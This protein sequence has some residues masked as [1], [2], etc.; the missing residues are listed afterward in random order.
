[1]KTRKI[2]TAIEDT[3]S[4]AGHEA[5]PPLRKVAVVAVIENPYAGK[6][7]QGDLSS[8]TEASE[9][10]GRKITSMAADAMFLK[11]GGDVPGE[12]DVFGID[13][14]VGRREQMGLMIRDAGRMG[15]AVQGE[16][17]EQEAHGRNRRKPLALPDGFPDLGRRTD[18]AH[19]RR[20]AVRAHPLRDHIGRIRSTGRPPLS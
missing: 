8:L 20:P 2:V 17:H 1:M 3:Y 13:A 7:Y 18:D 11:D 12:R 19:A 16:W 4:E 6:S 14:E 5:D 10:L 15:L 9:A